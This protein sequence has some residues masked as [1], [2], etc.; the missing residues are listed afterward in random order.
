V[1]DGGPRD[2]RT[3]EVLGRGGGLHW[4]SLLG[5][6]R[7]G[8]RLECQYFRGQQVHYGRQSSP[9]RSVAVVVLYD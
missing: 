5:P 9:I 8:D 3:V 6:E 4:E 1:P 2:I 7:R